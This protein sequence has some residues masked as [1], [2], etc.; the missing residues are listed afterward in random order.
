MTKIEPTARDLRKFGF[1]F[2]VVGI[3]LSGYL[4]YK[5]NPHWSWG[6]AGGG[7]FL[8]T[9]LFAH[10]IIR[11]IYIVWM[12]FAF[13]LGWINTRILLGV[14]FYLIFTPIGLAFRFIGKD[15]L[16]IRPDGRTSY[17]KKRD[18]QTFDKARYEEQF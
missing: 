8:L 2:T 10:P 17:W 9:G 11:P 12:K 18:H 5:G 16:M 1:L 4:L 13:I 6:L 14:C 7:F 15:L 3:V